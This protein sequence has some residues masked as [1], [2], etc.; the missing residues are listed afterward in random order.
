MIM[1]TSLLFDF[2]TIILSLLKRA[3]GRKLK[4]E[5]SEPLAINEYHK[6]SQL[7]ALSFRLS[8]L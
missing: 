6:P 8:A 5:S 1:V 3:K 2:A 7:L 4:A